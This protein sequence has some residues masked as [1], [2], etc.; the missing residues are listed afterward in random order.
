MASIPE[1]TCITAA[2][3]CAPRGAV[4]FGAVTALRHDAGRQRRRRRAAPQ[5]GSA[6]LSA[7]AASPLASQPSQER[8]ERS[9]F[10]AGGAAT[11]GRA[12]A[13][14]RFFPRIF[15]DMR[16]P[17]RRWH[18]LCS[19]SSCLTKAPGTFTRFI[20]LYCLYQRGYYYETNYLGSSDCA[21]VLRNC[22]RKSNQ[23]IHR[24]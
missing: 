10:A 3:G 2:I 20:F 14:G 1:P 23:H 4:A 13:A 8:Y 7:P 16:A 22:Q 21:R 11:A 6:A 15:K 9:R 19:S 17:P 18:L 12:G 5:S 24:R